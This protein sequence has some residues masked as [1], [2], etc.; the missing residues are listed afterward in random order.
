MTWLWI[1]GAVSEFSSREVLSSLRFHSSL[2]PP[3]LSLVRS[4]SSLAQ[5]VRCG[6][7]P[8]VVQSAAW[9]KPHKITGIS[10]QAGRSVFGTTEHCIL[11]LPIH[12]NTAGQGALNSLGD[13]P[14]CRGRACSTLPVI[15]YPFT[16]GSSVLDPY[17]TPGQ[18]NTRPTKV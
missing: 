2:R 10:V 15:F 17:N 4:V 16:E 1:S 7:P 14:C 9:T 5:P 8:K 6:S 11:K 12:M 18:A 13:D 3:I